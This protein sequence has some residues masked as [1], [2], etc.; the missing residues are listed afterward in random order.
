[1]DAPVCRSCGVRH[2]RSEPHKWGSE[3]KTVVVAKP[4]LKPEPKPEPKAQKKPV[5][6]VETKK[7]P[8][9]IEPVVVA[10]DDKDALIA[11]LRAKLAAYEEAEE[12]KRSYYREYMQNRR[13]R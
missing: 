5:V 9:G 4:D 13:G 10:V 11:E 2:W 8:Q 1:M 7:E 12:K 6:K 3:P